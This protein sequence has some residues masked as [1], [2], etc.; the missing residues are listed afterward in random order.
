MRKF[1][2]IS[3]ILHGILFS[4]FLIIGIL[5]K[6]SIPKQIVN[7]TLV[8]AVPN[9]KEGRQNQDKKE[10]PNSKQDLKGIS[11]S[12]TSS[13]S[14]KPR[15]EVLQ[16]PSTKSA[17]SKSKQ[18][19]VNA[20][21]KN[22]LQTPTQ[23]KNNT[24]PL[25]P[26][27]ILPSKD[28]SPTKLPPVKSNAI[29]KSPAQNAPLQSVP[30]QNLPMQKLTTQTPT[31]ESLS[32]LISN[33]MLA[34]PQATS[35]KDTLSAPT[36]IIGEAVSKAAGETIDDPFA[37]ETYSVILPASSKDS[38]VFEAKLP[39]TPNIN[40]LAQNLLNNSEAKNEISPA[41]PLIKNQDFTNFLEKVMLKTPK[42]QPPN[43]I[44]ETPTENFNGESNGTLTGGERAILARQIQQCWSGISS[45][46][47]EMVSFQLQL[48]MN[49]DATIN[50]IKITKLN[51]VSIKEEDLKD[52]EKR[53]TAVLNNPRCSKL[54][55]P[56]NKYSTWQNFSIKLNVKGIFG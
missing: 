8:K 5:S 17:Y 40:Q 35:A 38:P 19:F 36:Q 21:K 44:L 33:N 27:K 7:I 22:A 54:S 55:L 3:L 41:Q 53:I 30:I 4:I 20:V 49:Q 16:V 51:K 25:V 45:I 37:V 12:K 11:N 42:E 50:S 39:E 32:A 29:A 26:A 43:F 28:I 56:L 2:F 6:S 10:N 48:S 18:D 13:Q 15:A 9:A 46:K 24:L 52:L 34:L 31:N 47:D 23:G 1:F 14:L